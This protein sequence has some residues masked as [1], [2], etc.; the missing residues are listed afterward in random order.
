MD[1]DPLEALAGRCSHE[2]WR[3]LEAFRGHH[4]LRTVVDLLKLQSGQLGEQDVAAAILSLPET[5]DVLLS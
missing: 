1:T 3:I 4:D 5:S 2:A